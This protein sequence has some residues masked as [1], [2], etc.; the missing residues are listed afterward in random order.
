MIDD[1]DNVLTYYTPAAA[2]R[3]FRCSTKSLTKT[4]REFFHSR[5]TFTYNSFLAERYYVTFGLRH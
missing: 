5:G 1:A 4:A 2:L 3:T